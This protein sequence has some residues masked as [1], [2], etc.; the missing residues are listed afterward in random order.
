MSGRAIGKS[1][2]VHDNKVPIRCA[3][4]VD[5]Y[6]VNAEFNSRS[7]CIGRIGR[8]R[9]RIAPMGTDQRGAALVAKC[10]GRRCLDVDLIFFLLGCDGGVVQGAIQQ[11]HGCK[12]DDASQSGPW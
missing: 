6:T 5:F 7:K 8:R 10:F 11:V 1:P 12:Q 2:Y 3:G 9:G 4:D